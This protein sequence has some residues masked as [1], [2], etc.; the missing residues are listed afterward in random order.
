[1]EATVYVKMCEFLTVYVK[2]CEFLIS[3]YIDIQTN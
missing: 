2:M 3:L 1:M